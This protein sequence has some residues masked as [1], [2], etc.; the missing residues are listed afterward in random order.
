MTQT[1]HRPYSITSLTLSQNGLRRVS[2]AHALFGFDRWFGATQNAIDI[3][4][5]LPKALSKLAMPQ[6]RTMFA[7]PKR[8]L[9]RDYPS[10]C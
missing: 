4:R 1:G 9:P 2:P 10:I 5:G 8:E 3:G 6:E 7:R